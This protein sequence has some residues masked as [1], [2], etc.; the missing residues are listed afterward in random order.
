MFLDTAIRPLVT[1]LGALALL[2]T[3]ASGS[4]A[5]EATPDPT[6]ATDRGMA[7]PVSIHRGS[8]EAPVAQPIGPTVDTAVAGYDDDAELIGT[9][10]R[11][12]VMV[13]EAD[14]SA[15][16]AELTDAPHV[17]AVH[18]SAE[19]YG[20]I[21]ACGEIAGYEDD[22]RLIFGLRATEGS[23]V[24][25]IAILDDASGVV[26]RAL[27]AIDQEDLLGDGKLRMTVLVVAGDAPASAGS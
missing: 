17:I 20:E 12:P 18:A 23:S 16:L 4:A 2:V 11:P 15:T 9:A 3:A 5:Q 8:C 25:G 6:I 24:S 13:A 1:A 27:E 26:G 14:V 21:V 19:T 10:M 7:Y 22:G